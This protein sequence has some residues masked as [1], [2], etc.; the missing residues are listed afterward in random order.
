MVFGE[1]RG[2]GCIPPTGMWLPHPSTFRDA[3]SCEGLGSGLAVVEAAWCDCGIPWVTA[4]I[5]TG[6]ACPSAGEAG[7]TPL[8]LPHGDWKLVGWGMWVSANALLPQSGLSDWHRA[9][10]GSVGCRSCGGNAGW[11]AGC[12]RA[13]SKDVWVFPLPPTDCTAL[14]VPLRCRN[15]KHARGL[16][17]STEGREAVVA[18]VGGEEGEGGGVAPAIASLAGGGCGRC[19]RQEGKQ[20]GAK[21]AGLPPCPS[22]RG[23]WDPPPAHGG[24]CGPLGNAD[25]PAGPGPQQGRAAVAVAVLV[26]AMAAAVSVASGREVLPSMQLP[27]A[28]AGPWF[29]AEITWLPRFH[30]ESRGGRCQEP[31]RTPRLLPSMGVEQ[32][33]C[34][35]PG[36]L[37]PRASSPASPGTCECHPHLRTPRP[38]GGGGERGWWP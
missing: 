4:C 12:H 16:S 3:Q 9:E 34:T 7:S 36:P 29:P 35:E 31:A 20:P 28:L 15:V 26:V 37:S 23:R 30:G 11:G 19:V 14:V 2:A 5:Y 13:G 8:L 38:R 17:G 27:L 24:A 21:Q 32:R 18:L 33:G 6:A 22:P 25:G 10:H 1:R